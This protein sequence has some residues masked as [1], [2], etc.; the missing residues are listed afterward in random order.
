VGNEPEIIRIWNK[1]NVSV[2]KVNATLHG[3]PPH[4]RCLIF[5]SY[6]FPAFGNFAFTQEGPGVSIASGATG[7][8]DGP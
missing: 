5:L 7:F 3:A 8:Q 4:G 6:N 1:N 2:E